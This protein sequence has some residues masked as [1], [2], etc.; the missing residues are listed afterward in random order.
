[1]ALLVAF[2]LGASTAYSPWLL[3]FVTASLSFGAFLITK[4]YQIPKPDYF[5]VNGFAT[6]YNFQK[7]LHEILTYHVWGLLLGVV[8]SVIVGVKISRLLNLP[9]SLWPYV[10][11]D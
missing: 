7:P 10:P 2:L 5:C 9:F 3:P 6:G 11:K 1:M 8:V 4:L